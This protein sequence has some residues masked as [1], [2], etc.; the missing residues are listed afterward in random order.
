MSHLDVQS[1]YPFLSLTHYTTAHCFFFWLV[2]Q[3]LFAEVTV[4]LLPPLPESLKNLKRYHLRSLAYGLL[5]YND[6][7]PRLVVF[8]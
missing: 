3:L 4:I 5:F 1:L 6:N 8:F 7:L 2:L